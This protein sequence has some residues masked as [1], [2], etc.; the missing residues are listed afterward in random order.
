[1]GAWE[2]NVLG[3]AVVDDVCVNVVGSQHACLSIPRV[4]ELKLY[5]ADV[6]I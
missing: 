2:N 6:S 5:C 1:M 4:L 3:V